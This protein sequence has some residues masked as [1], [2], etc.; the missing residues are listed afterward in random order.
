MTSASATPVD[1]LPPA[2]PTGLL[3]VPGPDLVGGTAVLSWNANAEP[4]VVGYHVYRSLTIAGS[5]VRVNAATVT[6]TTYPDSGLTN[7]TVYYYQVHALDGTNEGPASN[8]AS[9]TPVDR[10]PPAAPTGVSAV[11]LPADQ[12]FGRV[13]DIDL[14]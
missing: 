13:V 6:A 12:G 11:D 8:T 14:H 9:V 10:I 2:A 3:A 1:N 5:F 4:D 7:G